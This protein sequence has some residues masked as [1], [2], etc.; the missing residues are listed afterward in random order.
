MD[1]G[2]DLWRSVRWDTNTLRF[3]EEP[4]RLKPAFATYTA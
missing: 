4:Q 3:G 2:N 1:I